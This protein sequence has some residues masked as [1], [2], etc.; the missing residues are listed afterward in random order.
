MCKI[1]YVLFLALFS[2]MATAQNVAITMDDFRLTDDPL[3]SGKEKDE[4]ILKTLAKNKVDIALF[5][6]GSE[7]EKPLS[8]QRL[9]V[10][11]RTNHIIA[12][13]TYS[14]A[15]YN[16]IAFQ[17][18]SEDILN[19]ETVLS[20]YQRFQKYFR[21]T[22]LKEGDTQDKRD[23]LRTFLK[24]QGYKQ[25]YVTIDASDWY[26]NARL[27]ARLKLNPNADTK[28]YRDYYLQHIWER[29]QFYD[30]LAQK[31]LGRNV[32]HT[33][34]IHHNLLNALFLND[35]LEMFRGKGWTIISARDAFT[36]PIF[37]MEP[38]IVPAGES[39]LWGLTK[40]TGR[41]ENL[42]RYPAED[43]IYEKDAM[44]KLGL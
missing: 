42:L 27:I 26:V 32:K 13:H 11:N 9:A 15:P 18:F 2:N 19:A 3:L 39:I 22:M 44:D 21:F 8:A 43:E 14:H 37:Q 17:K 36:D 29:T 33:L 6:I 25:G 16:R 34:L 4:R 5:V 31:V 23:Q 10:W 24:R 7:A 28:P 40:E 20:K 41:F 1:A 30:N 38:K 12:N 35:L